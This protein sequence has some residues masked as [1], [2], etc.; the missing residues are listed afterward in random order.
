MIGKLASITLPLAALIQTF[1]KRH[2]K[3]KTLTEYDSEWIWSE[4]RQKWVH[5]STFAKEIH[6]AHSRPTYEEWKAAQEIKPNEDINF[7]LVDSKTD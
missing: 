1:K 7:I 4:E 6:K 2:K 5:E 3:S